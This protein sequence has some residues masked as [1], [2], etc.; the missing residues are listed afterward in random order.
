MRI[1]ITGGAGFIGS[2][3]CERLLSEGHQVEVIDDLSTGNLENLEH[4]KGN[5]NFRFIYDTVLSENTMHAAVDR[6]DVIYHLAAAVG[7]DL[8]VRQPVRTIETNIKGTEVVLDIARKYNRKV[9]L[10]STSEVYGKNEQ[11]PFREEDDSLF[12]ATTYS[13]WSYA[14]SKAIDEF[15][16]LAYHKQ[17]GLPVIIARFFNTVGERQSGQYGMV[18]PRFVRAALAGEPIT[19]YGDGKQSRCF[20][21]VM[22]VIDGITSLVNDHGSYGQVFN[23]GSTEEISI[24]ALAFKIKSLAGSSS[25]IIYLPY[26]EAYG[27]GFDDM[28]RR[29]PSLDKIE[30]QV[31]YRPKTSL[32]QILEKII[33][34][35]RRQG[36]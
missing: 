23:I 13:R 24:E 15:L 11:V 21:Y 14:C 6:C 20:G 28:R 10:A 4:C 19:I 22:D 36:N 12:G 9:L 16:G 35:F 1:L 33:A 30:K 7:V 31:G 29:I 32:N 17:Y 34:Y 2:H 27:Q 18:I 26:E 5:N 3:L 25:E 8:I